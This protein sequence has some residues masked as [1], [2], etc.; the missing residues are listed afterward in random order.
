MV[1][2]FVSETYVSRASAQP[3]KE[4][5]SRTPTDHPISQQGSKTKTAPGIGRGRFFKAGEAI[6]TPDIHVGN[7]T[8]YH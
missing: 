4:G 2:G 8:L 7:V 6:R 1:G 3:L 5:K